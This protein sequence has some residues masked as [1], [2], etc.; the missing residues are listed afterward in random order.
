MEP[1][2]A[3]HTRD[4]AAVPPQELEPLWRY[5][6]QWWQ[7]TFLWGITAP[8]EA[9]RRVV[10]RRGVPGQVVY[11]GTQAVGYTYYMLHG[12]Q[13]MLSGLV[14]LPEWNTP[15]VGTTLLQATLR[16]LQQQSMRRL[17]SPC[18]SMAS[19]QLVPVFEQAGFCTYWRTFL[20]VAL[21]Q[22]SWPVPHTPP[23]QLLPWQ[24]ASL[25]REAI[26]MA[27][28]YAQTVDI[29]LNALYRTSEGC[30][31]VLD[32]LVNQGGCGQLVAEASA[33][34]YIQGQEVGFVLITEISPR[35]GHVAQIAVAPASQGQG[36][37]Q[38]LLAY[39]LSQLASLR[40]HTLSLIV[41]QA[42]RRALQLYQAVGMRPVLSFPVFVWEQE[43]R[44][45]Y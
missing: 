22:A 44:D 11:A 2:V 39:A 20:R 42:N 19:T 35:Q 14:V 6:A 30:H 7:E 33:C 28:A 29:Q 25:E 21:Q 18:M 5:E 1:P 16:A 3:L 23:L 15:E 17:E 38:A 10:E 36:I 8:L 40:F 27:A 31:A 32:S 13:G 41:S 43:S 26:L 37:G 9:L 12:Q 24:S 34:A 45:P 4:L